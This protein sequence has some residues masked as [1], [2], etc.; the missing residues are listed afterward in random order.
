MAAKILVIDDEPAIVNLVTAYLRAEGFEYLSAS[1]GPAGLAAARKAVSLQP[2]YPP[3]V[4]ALAEALSKT[5]DSKASHASYQHAL[6]LAR[7]APPGP[8][9]EAWMQDAEDGLGQK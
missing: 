7:A 2:D 3:N 6:E 1:D 8:E 9:R 4:L 5:G